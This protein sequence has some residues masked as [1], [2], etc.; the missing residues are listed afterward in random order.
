LIREHTEKILPSRSLWV[1]FELGRPLG[2]PNDPEFQLDVLRSLLNLFTEESGPVIRDYPHDSPVAS[3]ADQAWSCVIP[4]PPLEQEL[5]PAA[6]LKQSLQL[7]VGSLTPWYS[8]SLSR[9]GRTTFGLS[10]LDATSMPEVAGYLADLAS[11]E[12]TEYPDGFD[13]S[14]PNAVRYLFDDVKAFYM[15]AA[16]EQPGSPPPGGDRMWEWFF[17]ET[18]MGQVFYDVRDRTMADHNAK[19]EANRGIPPGPP[20]PNPVPARFATRPDSSSGA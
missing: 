15:E 16:S 5:T 4:L 18:R 14:L 10:G 1:P 12:K 11:G 6:A 7:E 2:A 17:Y 3:T 9:S 20:P 19:I 13:T 8:E